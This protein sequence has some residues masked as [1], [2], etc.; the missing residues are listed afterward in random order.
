[1]SINGQPFASATIAT[2]T[3]SATY[4]TR[5][6][7]R[8]SALTVE[9]PILAVSM[10]GGQIGYDLVDRFLYAEI[11]TRRPVVLDCDMLVYA[12][13]HYREIRD[14]LATCIMRTHPLGADRVPKNEFRYTDFWR[15]TA[16]VVK[17]WGLNE[18]L[19]CEQ[20]ADAAQ[21]ELVE[22]AHLIRGMCES[23]DKWWSPNE[24]H[25]QIVSTY[26][27]RTLRT[28]ISDS[29]SRQAQLILVRELLNGLPDVLQESGYRLL[30]DRQGTGPTATYKVR[31]EE[32]A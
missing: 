6:L 32:T 27:H 18:D 22:L 9:R 4:E 14:E 25:D 2:M 15:H 13:Q 24:I 12:E 7:G 23:C 1:M 30:V 29:L 28:V 5:S 17:A 3:T 16:P 11:T 8:N 19:I 31:L 26:H 21:S 10:Q 20:A